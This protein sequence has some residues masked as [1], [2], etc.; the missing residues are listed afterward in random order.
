[1]SPSSANWLLLLAGI[2]MLIPAWHQTGLVRV[3]IIFLALGFASSAA[4]RQAG[5]S[6]AVYAATTWLYYLSLALIVVG[7]VRQ[8]RTM[9]PHLTGGT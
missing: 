3:G 8:R 7:I 4:V 6:P 1:M 5:A 2:L 9:R